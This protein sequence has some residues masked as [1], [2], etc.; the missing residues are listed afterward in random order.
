MPRLRDFD[1]LERL[2]QR[3]R[4]LRE[5]HRLTQ[6]EF[7]ERVG[8]EAET[9]SRVERGH[10]PL[11]VANLARVATVFG[12]PI[13]AL[14]D[15]EVPLPPPALEPGELEILAAYRALPPELRGVAVKMLRSMVG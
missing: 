12:V 6:A 14:V 3:L 8:L 9:V 5:A 10:Q 13:A 4:A 7:G 1:L 11:S 15:P 2:G